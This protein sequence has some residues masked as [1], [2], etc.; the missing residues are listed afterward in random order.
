[1]ATSYNEAKNAYNKFIKESKVGFLGFYF[2]RSGELKNFLEAQKENGAYTGSYTGIK[3]VP[4]EKIRGS[5]QKYMDFDKN[6]VPKNEVILI[7]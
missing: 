6:F 3:D 2:S 7:S 4:I 5:V 1:M